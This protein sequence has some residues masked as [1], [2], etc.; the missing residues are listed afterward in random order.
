MKKIIILGFSCIAICS[1]LLFGCGNDKPTKDNTPSPTTQVD[2]GSNDGVDNKAG[3]EKAGYT[4]ED[5]KDIIL[6]H[7]NINHEDATFTDT[8]EEQDNGVNKYELEF[9]SNGKKYEYEVDKATGEIL[10]YDTD[11]D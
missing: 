5:A 10:S 9:T 8:H 11:N 2:D 4:L 7:A 3:D 6:K 1:I